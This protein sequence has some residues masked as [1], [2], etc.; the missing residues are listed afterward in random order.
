MV[1]LKKKT[2]TNIQS[3]DLKL[4]KK[5]RSWRQNTPTGA[6]NPYNVPIAHYIELFFE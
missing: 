1:H 5:L 6:P 3:S 2:T 4:Q